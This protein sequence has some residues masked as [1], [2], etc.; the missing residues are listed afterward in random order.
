MMI[1]GKWFEGCTSDHCTIPD[2]WAKTVV[3][4]LKQQ[5]QFTLEGQGNDRRNGQSN[6]G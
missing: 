6:R 2:V 3:N 4:K 1:L 5:I